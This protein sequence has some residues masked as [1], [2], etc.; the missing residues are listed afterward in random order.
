[1]KI[2]VLSVVG[3]LVVALLVAVHAEEP[4]EAAPLEDGPDG[5]MDSYDAPENYDPE[6]AVWHAGGVRAGG[7]RG[8]GGAWHAGG[9]RTGGFRGGGAWHAGGFHRGW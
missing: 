3:L 6:A 5:E 8:G 4:A 2:Q 1:M 7:Y 9:V